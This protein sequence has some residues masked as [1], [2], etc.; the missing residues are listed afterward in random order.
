M[1]NSGLI[2][3]NIRSIIMHIDYR[4]GGGQMDIRLSESEAKFLSMANDPVNRQHL[5]AR[6]E[7]LGLLSAFLAAENG[8]SQ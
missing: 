3:Q 1:E 5:L 2:F 6:L 4:K 7:Q 8:T